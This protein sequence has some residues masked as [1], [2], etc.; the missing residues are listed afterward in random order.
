[1]ITTKLIKNAQTTSLMVEFSDQSLPLPIERFYYNCNEE[2]V[3]TRRKP[4]KS[5]E[6]MI[7]H[8]LVEKDF[9]FNQIRLKSIPTSF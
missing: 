3:Y 1:M 7:Y 4:Q 2:N 9:E 5:N 8:T 6:I